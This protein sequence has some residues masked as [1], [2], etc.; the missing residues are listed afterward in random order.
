M[1]WWW[2]DNGDRDKGQSIPLLLAHPV[3][4]HGHM[5]C[6]M[7]EEKKKPLLGI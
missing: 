2:R 1:G 4:G 3:F 5:E 6:K 7:S